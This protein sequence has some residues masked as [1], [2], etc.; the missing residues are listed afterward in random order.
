MQGGALEGRDGRGKAGRD[1]H[2]EYPLYPETGILGDMHL[3]SGTSCVSMCET[4]ER[5]VSG[6]DTKGVVTSRAYVRLTALAGQTRF[7]VGF[8][9]IIENVRHTHATIDA[10][11][12]KCQINLGIN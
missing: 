4:G 10:F 9:G 7:Y 8:R 5:A 11:C 1:I 6:D 12:A 3:V 2:T